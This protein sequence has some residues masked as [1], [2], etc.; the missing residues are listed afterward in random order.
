MRSKTLAVAG[1]VLAF[2]FALLLEQ[3]LRGQEKGANAFNLV[4]KDVKVK[5]K[6]K[7]GNSWDINDGKPDIHVRITNRTNTS[8]KPF[9]SEVR[10]DTYTATYNQAAM[11]V[12]AKQTLEIEV[13][14]KDVAAD[15][16]IGRTTIEITEDMLKRGNTE[17][18]FGQVDSL[19][20]EFQTPKK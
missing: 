3:G 7:D 4:L 13:L 1:I 17:L 8:L 15:D 6:N 12:I 5:D 14:D 2:G 18:T 11:L 16:V 10:D 9:S 20:F 19:R